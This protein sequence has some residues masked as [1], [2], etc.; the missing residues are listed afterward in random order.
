MSASGVRRN[1]RPW[2][3]SALEFGALMVALGA[4]LSWRQPPAPDAASSTQPAGE[5]VPAVSTAKLLALRNLGI[6]QVENGQYVEASNTFRQIA[7][8]DD[9]T[10]LTPRNLLV[11]AVLA[12]ETGEGNLEL[13]EPLKTVQANLDRLAELG[14]TPE[15]LRWLRYRTGAVGAAQASDAATHDARLEAV[16]DWLDRDEPARRD[17]RAQY[18][19]PPMRR[20]WAPLRWA[21][22]TDCSR[23]TCSSWCSI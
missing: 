11:A 9:Q 17:V 13:E 14:D 22:L 5:L 16:R 6:A 19:P 15:A 20:R 8:A 21:G 7:A 2:V 10:L 12:M 4:W 3:A 18:A 1:W 23:T